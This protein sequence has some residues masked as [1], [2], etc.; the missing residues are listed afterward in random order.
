MDKEQMNDKLRK[1]INEIL[2]ET[3][4]PM[5]FLTSEKLMI[6]FSVTM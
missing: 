4:L 1:T 3:S 6:T 2:V 5:F